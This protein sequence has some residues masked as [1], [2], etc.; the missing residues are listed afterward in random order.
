MKSQRL[1][2][3][4]A[5]T[6]W[7]NRRVFWCG[8]P[9]RQCRATEATKLVFLAAAARAGV[10]STRR[11]HVAL[12]PRIPPV[13]GN[14]GGPWSVIRLLSGVPSKN[15][16]YAPYARPWAAA[17]TLVAARP[18]SALSVSDRWAGPGPLRRNLPAL[19]R[20]EAAA[21]RAGSH[22]RSY[23]SHPIHSLASACDIR[24]K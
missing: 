21:T 9:C 10:V 12:F 8:G 23:G 5:A 16:P 15:P 18:K 4:P 20:L 19:L 14:R 24:R 2:K 7:R 1:L 17:K 3:R 6:A 11:T 22:D 13:V